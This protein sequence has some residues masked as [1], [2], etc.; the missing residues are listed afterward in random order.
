MSR[1]SELTF[2]EKFKSRMDNMSKDGI[3]G[4]AKDIY[5]PKEKKRDDENSKKGIF[6]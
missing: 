1:K 5:T 3:H 2:Q 4:L 6:Y